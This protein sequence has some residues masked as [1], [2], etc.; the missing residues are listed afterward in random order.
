MRSIALAPLLALVACGP[1]PPGR[2]A[3]APVVIARGTLAYDARL[4]GDRVIGLELDTGFALIVHAL[5][6]AIVRRIDLGGPDRD[7]GALAIDDRGARAWVGGEDQAVRAIELATGA[8]TAT[9]PIG[10]DV[11]ALAWVTA[12]DR[13][14]VAIGDATGVACLRRATDGAVV[15]C[16]AIADAPITG[17]AAEADA[18]VVTAGARAIRLALPGLQVRGEAAAPPA[19]ALPPEA[20]FGGAIRARH[21]TPRGVLVAAWIR[22]L[23]DPSIVWFRRDRPAG[24]PR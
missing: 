20:R 6:G 24:C 1:L 21:A 5:D 7:L 3:P 17:L 18:L 4:V 13:A 12:D 2:C 8:I 16:V 15:Q 10:A 22:T 11:T 9:W 14:Y 23:D 19:P